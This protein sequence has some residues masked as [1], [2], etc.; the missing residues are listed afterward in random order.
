MRNWGDV[1]A[2]LVTNGGE[3]CDFGVGVCLGVRGGKWSMFVK[4]LENSFLGDE[5]R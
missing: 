5:G 1:Y 3:S 2:D 4:N